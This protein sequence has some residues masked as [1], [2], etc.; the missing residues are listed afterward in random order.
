MRVKNV[1]MIGIA[2]IILSHP[3]Q[4]EPSAFGSGF[5]KNEFYRAFTLEDITPKNQQKWPYYKYVSSHWDGYAQYG[6][7]KVNRSDNPTK[8]T[9][10]EGKEKFDLTSE[11]REGKSF[12]DSFTDT[13]VKGFVVIKD[14]KIIA[15]YYD[16]GFMVEDTNLL[17]S[18]SKT[19]AGVIT[20]KLVDDGKINPN[21]KIK[22]YIKEFKG[23]SIG[24]ATVQQVL[25][26]TSGLPQLLDFHTPG[27]EGYQYEIEIGLKSGEVKGHKDQIK[28]SK[29]IAKPGEKW[30]Y[31]DKN[32]DTLA[33]LAERVTGRE[34]SELLSELYNEFGAN[35]DGSIAKT[36]DD[37]NAP[38][39]GISITA[40]DYALF[41]QWI[42]QGKAP[43]SYYKSAMDV[44]KTEFGKN[45]TA[46]LLGTDVTYGSQT[47]YMKN[48]DILYSSGSFGQLGFSDMKTGASVVFL[49]DWAVNAELDKYYESRERAVKIFEEL[50]NR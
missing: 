12:I 4:A 40:R 5:D 35:Y 10:A 23:S 18:A 47:Y 8:L 30:N 36:S 42:A 3:V 13:Q 2:G 16:N 41:H 9:V 21:K 14:S 25:D 27:T 38:S 45:E 1:I 15:E 31:T 6:T 17:Q 46:K 37:T 22:T 19:F 48:Q 11:F 39:Y 34:Y 44:S 29:A 28:S 7:D 43:K 33:L 26:M 32:T 20:G 50:R 24:E 49:Q